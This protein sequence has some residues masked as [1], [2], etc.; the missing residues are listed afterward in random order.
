MSFQFVT[1]DVL[2]PVLVWAKTAFGRKERVCVQNKRMRTDNSF[3]ARSHYSLGTKLFI[4]SAPLRLH[5]LFQSRGCDSI[6]RLVRPYV[7]YQFLKWVMFSK[8]FTAF[9]F[10]FSK[11]EFQFLSSC[12]SIET[13]TLYN[14]SYT[15]MSLRSILVSQL[16]GANIII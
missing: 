2:N 13:G 15:I 12:L 7:G 10:L 14:M 9:F 8:L 4:N 16:L 1:S 6:T 5:R 11:Y 3:D